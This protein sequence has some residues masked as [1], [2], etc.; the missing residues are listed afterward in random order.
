MRSFYNTRNYQY[1]WFSSNGL[2]EQ[3]LG[4]WNLR[5]Y[6]SYFGDTTLNHSALKKQMDA[7]TAIDT[8]TVNASDK[9]ILNTELSLTQNFISYILDKYDKGYVKRK[10][11]ERF[12]PFVKEDAVA[13]A[14]SLINKK[15]KDDKYFEDV[16]TDYKALK[17]ELAKYLQIVKSGG[18]PE[19]TGDAKTYKKG[20]S[21]PQIAVLK[22][23]LQISGDM[24][25]QDTS[26]LFDDT[27][28]NGIK[29]FQKRLGL[30][31]DGMF[32]H[33]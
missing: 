18:W 3:A 20:A 28:A 30:T 21:S 29:Q 16:N 33:H 13:V 9:S 4:F 22:K 7:L 24:P 25:A 8:L 19:I 27:L 12:V 2:T 15:H 17:A 32:Q 10:E 14:D 6:A 26:T 23:R 5:N 1:A 31:Q 11:M